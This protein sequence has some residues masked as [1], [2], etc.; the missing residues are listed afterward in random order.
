MRESETLEIQKVPLVEEVN[1]LA[2][3]QNLDD[4]S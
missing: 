1:I 2:K 3:H 4:V